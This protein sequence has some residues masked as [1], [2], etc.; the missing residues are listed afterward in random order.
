MSS[1]TY[2]SILLKLNFKIRDILLNSFKIWAFCCIIYKLE[3]NAHFSHLLHIFLSLS[4]RILVLIMILLLHHLQEYMAEK[5]APH[6]FFLIIY[7]FWFDNWCVFHIMKLG[8]WNEDTLIWF[9]WVWLF[10]PKWGVFSLIIF[11]IMVMVM[12]WDWVLFCFC[13]LCFVFIRLRL[14]SILA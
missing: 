4:I 9:N 2:N 10:R 6:L 7:E 13:L 12:V 11:E 14:S 5:W 3:T 1:F 8:F